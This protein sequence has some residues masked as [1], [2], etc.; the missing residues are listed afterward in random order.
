M[1]IIKLINIKSRLKILI[2]NLI[3]YYKFLFKMIISFI[4]SNNNH[5][6][7]KIYI[8]NYNHGYPLNNYAKNNNQIDI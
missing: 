8:H 3:I 5:N 4:W 1:L 2:I 6:N 7:L